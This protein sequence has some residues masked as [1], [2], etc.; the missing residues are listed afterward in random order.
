[1]EETVQVMKR[2]ETQSAKSFPSVAFVGYFAS[3]KTY[4]SNLLSKK[5]EEKGIKPYRV[6]IA[7]KIKEIAKDLFDMQG[8]DRRLLQLLGAKMREINENVWIDYLI[9]D[10][11]KNGKIPF[12]VDDVRFTNEAKIFKDNFDAFIVVRLFVDDDKRMDIYE[13]LYGR[14][15]TEDELKD[16]TET[17][18]DNIKY[19]EF[20]V[21]DYMPETAEK[22][23]ERLIEKYFK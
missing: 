23:I 2:E 1:M 13:K 21:N 3:G 16:P 15:P 6:S 19:D 20:I 22:E 12:I 8:K 4:Y 18:I 7:N 5:L 11:K 14:R 9:R 10:I 17:D